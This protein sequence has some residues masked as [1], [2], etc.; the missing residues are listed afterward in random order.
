MTK[1]DFTLDTSGAGKRVSIYVQVGKTDAYKYVGTTKTAE[2]C[3]SAKAK[4]LASN[5]HL[6]EKQVH[7]SFT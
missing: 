3:I 2:T 1:T 7:A 6:T 5:P 4:F